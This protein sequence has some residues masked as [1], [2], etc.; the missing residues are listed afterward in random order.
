MHHV[1]RI[2]IKQTAAL[3]LYSFFI[4]NIHFQIFMNLLCLM[5]MATIETYV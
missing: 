4:Y 1:H 3:I 5:H 2:F